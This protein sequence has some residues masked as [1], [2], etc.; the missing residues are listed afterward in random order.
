MPNRTALTV[1]TG[2]HRENFDCAAQYF[3]EISRP[4]GRG[5]QQGHFRRFHQYKTLDITIMCVILYVNI[6]ITNHLT[7]M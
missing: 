1:N 3:T 2:G 7:E 6:D 4:H 5:R